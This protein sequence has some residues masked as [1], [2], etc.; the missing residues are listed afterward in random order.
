[1]I[2]LA[3]K[4]WIA[5]APQ[6]ATASQP[7]VIRQPLG[8]EQVSC[9]RFQ[10]RLTRTS[11]DYDAAKG[12]VAESADL[13]MQARPKTHG[14]KQPLHVSPAVRNRLAPKCGFTSPQAIYP[15]SSRSR[16]GSQKGN[17]TSWPAEC[18]P[19]W[20]RSFAQMEVEPYEV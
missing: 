13:S 5:S 9:H 17:A 14:T 4:A 15:G 8:A 10:V 2:I 18:L 20:F 11:P 1:M 7:P 12:N 3:G 19:S 6:K 16:S